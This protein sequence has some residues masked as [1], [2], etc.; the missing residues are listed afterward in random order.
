MSAEDTVDQLL[1]DEGV[2]ILLDQLHHL[3]CGPDVLLAVLEALD[4]SND[5]IHFLRP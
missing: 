2:M 5:G 3:L 1:P 4:G